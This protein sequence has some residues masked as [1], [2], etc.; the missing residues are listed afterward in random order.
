M[1]PMFV[2]FRTMG[3]L[4][5]HCLSWMCNLLVGFEF[6]KFGLFLRVWLVFVVCNESRGWSKIDSFRH[7][8]W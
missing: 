7:L 8:D 6:E 5:M 4:M 1:R 3:R 2:G